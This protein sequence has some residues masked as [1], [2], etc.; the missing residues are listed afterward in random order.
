MNA[1]LT[2]RFF[3]GFKMKYTAIKTNANYE[4]GK[5]YNLD[6]NSPRTLSLLQAGIIE[7]YKKVNRIKKIIKPSETK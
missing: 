5:A 6:E 1:P 3:K 7:P 4:T 2:G